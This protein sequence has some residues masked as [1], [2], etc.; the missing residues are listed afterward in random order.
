MMIE[1]L[2]AIGAT[3]TC[4][5]IFAA[6]M[7]AANKSRQK[8]EYMNSALGL[9][10]KQLEAIKGIDPSLSVAALFSAGIIDSTIPVGTNQYSFTNADLANLDNPAKVLPSGKGVITVELIDIE[11][12][13]VTIDVTW[14]EGS[15]T[16]AIKIGTLVANLDN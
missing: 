8:A 1:V 14:K 6:T 4:A 10:Q 13:R 9:A 2:F 12:R 5:L 3:V 11:L 7:P 16:R 15:E